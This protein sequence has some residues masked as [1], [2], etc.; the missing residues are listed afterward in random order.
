ME[1]GSIV[2]VSTEE[3]TM[4]CEESA[5]IKHCLQICCRAM[6]D[7]AKNKWIFREKSL[8]NTGGHTILLVRKILSRAGDGGAA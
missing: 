2:S 8:P 7:S 4:Y 5:K 1:C 6:M 3:N